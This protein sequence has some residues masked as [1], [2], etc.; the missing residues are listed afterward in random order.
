MEE[1]NVT[2]PEETTSVFKDSEALES[3]IQAIPG[4]QEICSFV[5][6]P[7]EQFKEVSLYINM[8]I[9][10]AYSSENF[11]QEIRRLIHDPNFDYPALSKSFTTVLQEIEKL[12][13]IDEK[14]TF[15][16]NIIQGMIGSI[17]DMYENPYDVL[18]PVQLLHADAKLPVYVHSGDAGA[19]IFLTEDLVV[20]AHSFG[21]KIATGIA[22][23]LPKGWQI[24]IRP[25]SGKSEKTR[26]RISNTPGTID[27]G[28]RDE[29]GILI[30][31]FGEEIT[32]KKG[33]K[34]A[35]IV[36]Q[37]VYRARFVTTED[38]KSIGED[39]GGGFG[40]SDDKEE[41]GK[42]DRKE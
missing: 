38:V 34:L 14:K 26:V 2:I 16:Y 6:L 17:T 1:I 29:I 11:K 41:D 36:V 32:F 33:D 22:C 24:E 13:C 7:D 18:V 37:P 31:N 3:F 4:L 25:R 5:E 35:Q 30:D 10:E 12:K 28:Y 39:R 23:A 9:E 15:L 8:T 42:E 21:N 19:D 20:P 27:G 40:H